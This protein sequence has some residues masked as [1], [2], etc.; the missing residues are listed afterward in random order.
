MRR[1]KSFLLRLYTNSP[2]IAKIAL[3]LHIERFSSIVQVMSDPIKKDS[4]SNP[5]YQNMSSNGEHFPHAIYK[6]TADWE[7]YKPP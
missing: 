5:P 7:S 3:K 6:M 1:F 4:D 2:A